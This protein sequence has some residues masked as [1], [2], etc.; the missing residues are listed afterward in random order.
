MPRMEEEEESGPAVKGAL[1]GT[2][3][4]TLYSTAKSAY[5]LGAHAGTGTTLEVTCYEREPVHVVSFSGYK[6]AVF[7]LNLPQ[8]FYAEQR[9]VQRGGG[10]VTVNL[11]GDTYI[12]R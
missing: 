12:S 8:D 4:K 9:V 5:N 3:G 10:Y 7:S 2:L 6:E 1:N 11:S